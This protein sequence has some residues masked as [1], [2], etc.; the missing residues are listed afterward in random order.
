MVRLHGLGTY[1]DDQIMAMVRRGKQ[2]G[3]IPGVGRVLAGKGKDILDVSVP[4]CNHTFDIQSQHESGSDSG[5]G[6]GEDDKLGDDENASDD[7][8]S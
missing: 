2:R 5:C 8:D 3:H 4:R 7:A 1:T 6:A